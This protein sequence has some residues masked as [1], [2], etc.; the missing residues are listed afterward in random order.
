VSSCPE[1][2]D[3][4]MS[5][6]VPSCDTR[7]D[8]RRSMAMNRVERVMNHTRPCVTGTDCVRVDTSTGCQGTCG[9]WVHKRFAE[10]AQRFIEHVDQRYCSAYRADGC[11]YVT[12]RCQGEVPACVRGRCTG[13]PFPGGH[14]NER[15]LPNRSVR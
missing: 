14:R 10:R 1:C 5:L 15:A 11:T 13:Q 7:C 9:T 12:P 2:D 4:A 6:C 3:C 8:E